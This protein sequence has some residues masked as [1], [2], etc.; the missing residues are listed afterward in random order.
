MWWLMACWFLVV[1]GASPGHLGTEE[2]K[3]KALDVQAQALFDQAR[4]A[5]GEVLL[6][7]SLSIRERLYDDK[8]LQVG[9]SLFNLGEMLLSQ[10]KHEEALSLYERS[11]VTLQALGS[12]DLLVAQVT[13]SLGELWARK[14]NYKV[15]RT[16]FEQSLAI[17][18]EGMEPDDPL[19]ATS[20]SCLDIWTSAL[21]PDHP[22]RTRPHQGRF[23][24]K[25]PGIAAEGGRR[26]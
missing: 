21:G 6:R 7:E 3:A 18:R 8:S 24:P 22:V 12:E 25:Q 1:A 17:R 9:S 10:E 20:L 26:L 4:F 13:N 16:H 14:G 15:A 11:L 2:E 5:E 19:F 23:D